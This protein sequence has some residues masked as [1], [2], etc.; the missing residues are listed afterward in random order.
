LESQLFYKGIRP[1]INIGLS[2][3]RVGSAA[4]IGLMKAIAGSLKLELA[5][6]REVEAFAS[7]ASDLDE[8]TQYT[9]NRGTRLIELLKQGQFDPIPVNV[10]IISIY[11]GMRGFLD[12]L[13][14]S[15]VTKF[16]INL[17]FEANKNTELLNKISTNKKFTPELDSEITNFINKVLNI[18]F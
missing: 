3:S 17:R 6:Y 4:Q 9:L 12:K 5:Q 15:D 7:F 11:A 16:D 14:V 8:A 13:A 1:A 18:Y 2:V 10:Q